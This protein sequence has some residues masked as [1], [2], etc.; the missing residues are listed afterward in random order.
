MGGNFLIVL[1]I[2]VQMICSEILVQFYL[3][4]GAWYFFNV[5]G[6]VFLMAIKMVLLKMSKQI[7]WTI[8]FVS[9]KKNFPQFFC[10]FLFFS[11]T[12]PFQSTAKVAQSTP[13]PMKLAFHDYISPPKC[14]LYHFSIQ[15]S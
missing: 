1:K 8:I 11:K 13:K 4:L 2:I 5:A 3:Q 10:N 6:P 12:F 15:K 14:A 7:I 9:L